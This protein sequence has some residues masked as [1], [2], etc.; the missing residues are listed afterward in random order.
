MPLGTV[1]GFCLSVRRR[2]RR[3][4]PFLIFL[5]ATTSASS[6]AADAQVGAVA[7]GA[8]AESTE[9][10]AQDA[11]GQQE[12]VA[13]G[14]VEVLEHERADC[15][16][17]N[18]AIRIVVERLALAHRRQHV[19]PASKHQK[20]RSADNFTTAGNRHFA[21]AITNVFTGEMNRDE[22]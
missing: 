5:C 14:G 20:F 22:R 1:G 6:V 10:V 19:G 8:G 12:A 4:P 18:K 21:N 15:L 2:M 9:G 3:V 13:A 11:A 16:A 17:R 7:T